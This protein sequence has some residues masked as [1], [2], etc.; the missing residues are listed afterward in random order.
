MV[1][2]ADVKEAVL[3]GSSYPVCCAK[4]AIGRL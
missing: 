4:F 1:S 2:E 3:G